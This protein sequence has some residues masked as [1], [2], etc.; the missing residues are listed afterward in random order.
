MERNTEPEKE[1]KTSLVWELNKLLSPRYR[2]LFFRIGYEDLLVRAKA[3]HP[4]YEVAE[5]LQWILQ[6]EGKSGLS[7]F[8]TLLNQMQELE[9]I[10]RI[11]RSAAGI[12]F[13][14]TEDHSL[15]R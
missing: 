13:L 3:E 14:S 4:G 7:K 12:L 5:L 15:F 9:C 8:Y 11:N 6:K 1:F 2:E 10:N